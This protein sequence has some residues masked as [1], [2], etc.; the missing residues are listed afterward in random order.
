MSKRIEDQV[1]ALA[2]VFQAATLVSQ[3]AH[4]GRCADT[5]LETSLKSLFATNPANTLEVYG[6]ELRNLREGLDAMVKILGNQNRQQDMEVLRYTLNLIQLESGLN[7]NPDMLSAIGERIDQAR[8]TASHFGY[9]HSNLIGNLASVYADTI[10][11]FRL[12]IQ[13]T[14]DPNVLQR[15]ENAAKVRALLLSG[16]RSAVLWRQSGGRRWQLII[17]RRKLIAVARALSEQ[18]NQ[19]VYHSD[20]SPH[21]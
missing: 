3:L 16:I 9:R 20:D 8:H 7:R 21:R 19:A 18:A 1:L 14:G 10:S 12:R 6:G 17:R 13:V 2:G 5:S 4:Q 11:T 15:E